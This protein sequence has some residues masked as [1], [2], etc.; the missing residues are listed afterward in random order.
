VSYL[1]QKDL[2]VD[3]LLVEDD[4]Q[5]NKTIVSFLELHNDHVTSVT[6]GME[7][8]NTIDRENFDFFIIDI[9]LPHISGLELT[10]YIREKYPS[11]PIIIITASLEVNNFIDAF[12]SGCNEYIKKP[13]HLKELEI[14]MNKLIQKETTLFFIT[15]S[16]G[17]DKRFKELIIDN[18]KIELRKK[19]LR[20]L[21]I[22]IQNSNHIVETHE[23]ISYIWEG[24]EK[25]K[26]PLRQLVNELRKKLQNKDIISTEV[27]LGYRLNQHL[28]K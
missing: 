18:Q 4:I 8:I 19:E 25:D 27:G 22:L 11:V 17:Y 12:E 28:P 7:A 15:E 21:D 5:L 3:I 1:G 26:Y 23:L 13:F 10:S 6:D 24:E 16:I 2:L 14:R 20:L 9:N